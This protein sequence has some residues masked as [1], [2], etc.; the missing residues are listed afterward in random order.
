MSS[1]SLPLALLLTA[2]AACTPQ[3]PQSRFAESE[4][5]SP[6]WCQAAK[7]LPNSGTHLLSVG[8][9]HER[10]VA[11]FPRNEEVSLFYYGQAA[12]WGSVDA[13]A[14]LAR[15]NRPVPEADLLAEARDRAERQQHSQRMASAVAASVR[16]AAPARPLS[17]L[18]QQQL[19]HERL[20]GRAPLIAPA[21]AHF[22]RPAPQP[23]LHMMP[24]PAAAPQST[25]HQQSSRTT[26]S[27]RRNCVNGVCRTERVTCVNGTCTTAIEN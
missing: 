18:E 9:C 7:A 2:L 4:P 16:P 12:R 20:M 11:G 14:E 1:P 5:F 26:S 3:S 22:R 15:R 23:N 10:D 19:N 21:P 25:F 6:E 24:R 8:R 27:V 17:A 13:G